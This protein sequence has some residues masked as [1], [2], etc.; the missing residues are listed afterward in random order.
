MTEAL[1]VESY[2]KTT[3]AYFETALKEKDSRESQS[4]QML[5]LIREGIVFDFCFYYNS[6]LNNCATMMRSVISGGKNNYSSYYA[7]LSKVYTK[8]LT[9][10]LAK[11]E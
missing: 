6:Q 7:M 9:T 2:R 4:S 3:T 8:Q 1:A 11:Y 10:L 5:D